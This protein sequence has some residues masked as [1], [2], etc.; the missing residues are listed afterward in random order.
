MHLWLIPTEHGFCLVDLLDQ[1]SSATRETRKDVFWALNSRGHIDAAIDYVNC[2]HEQL[3]RHWRVC[4]NNPH[5]YAKPVGF[6]CHLRICP[7]CA[8]RRAAKILE[9]YLPIARKCYENR[10]N[11]YRLRHVTLTTDWNLHDPDIDKRIRQLWKALDTML[12]ALWGERW[13]KKELGWV[14]GFEFGEQGQNL[15]LHLMLY[16]DYIDQND[17][18]KAWFA[19]SGC[20]VVYISLIRGVK[21]GLK[22]VLKYATKLTALTPD[23]T[24][25]V[26]EVLKG[27]RRVR[28]GGVFYNAPAPEKQA[29][30]LCKVCK[31][32]IKDMQCEEFHKLLASESERLPRSGAL[33]NLIHGNKSANPPPPKK[34]VQFGVLIRDQKI[35]TRLSLLVSKQ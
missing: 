10:T 32:T 2:G 17:L 35:A 16:C 9:K 34:Q 14:G 13:N 4:S 26:H 19:A 33:L 1:T 29:V 27:V 11:D 18:S 25:L 21:K 8:R 3:I 30:Q 28:A 6:S 31:H 24:A 23:D 15:H 20:S 12:T 7:D 5:H 22:E